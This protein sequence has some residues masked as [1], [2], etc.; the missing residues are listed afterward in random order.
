M[1]DAPKTFYTSKQINELRASAQHF[2]LDAP[3]EFWETPASVLNKVCNG[4]GP[5]RWTEL[6]RKALTSALKLYEPAF[7][8]HDVEYEYQLGTQKKADKRMKKNMVKIWRKSFGIWRWFSK[9][10]RIERLVVISSVC[11]HVLQA[12]SRIHS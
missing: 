4:A 1:S 5:D 6:K 12:L 10:G 8:I 3:E 9:A 2:K 11:T 7:A